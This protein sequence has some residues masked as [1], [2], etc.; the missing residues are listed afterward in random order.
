MENTYYV[1][2]KNYSKMFDEQLNL[3]QI[4]NFITDIVVYFK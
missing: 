3:V 1:T 2:I 4:M